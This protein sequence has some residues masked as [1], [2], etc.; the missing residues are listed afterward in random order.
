V[1][2][3]GVDETITVHVKD[4]EFVRMEN[5]VEIHKITLQEAKTSA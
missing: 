4:R 2:H 1:D 5:D 3:D